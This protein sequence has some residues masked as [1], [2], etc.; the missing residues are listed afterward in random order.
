M[1]NLKLWDSVFKSDPAFTKQVNQRGGYTS[2]SPQ[3]LIKEAT[4]AFGSYG[5]GWGFESVKMDYAHIE[6]LGLV[7]VDAVFFYLIDGERHTF[8]INN[9]WSAKQGARVDPDFV[10]KAETN[11]MCKALS[12]LGFAGDVFMG[13][14]DNPDYV[15]HVASVK[16]I[17]KADNIEEEQ[18]KQALEWSEWK[19]KELRAY[20]LVPNMDALKAVYTRH[21]KKLKTRGDEQAIIMFTKAKDKRKGEL[22]EVV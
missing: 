21:I 1:S 7:M 6:S 10:K 22:D 17:E 12:K 9:S 8:P 18:A 4:N 19:V 5:K 2:V 13:L 16:A 20:D 11:T 3:Y 15:E 14:F